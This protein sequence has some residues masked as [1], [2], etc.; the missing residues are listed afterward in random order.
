M[1]CTNTPAYLRKGCLCLRVCKA[2]GCE[3]RLW[4]PREALGANR[5][6]ARVVLV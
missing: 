6:V 3:P 2:R 4:S 5:G 1:K